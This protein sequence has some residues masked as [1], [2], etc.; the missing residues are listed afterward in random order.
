[1]SEICCLNRQCEKFFTYSFLIAF[2]VLFTGLTFTRHMSWW[3]FH[4]KSLEI[5]IF[6]LA[7]CFERGKFVQYLRH[8]SQHVHVCFGAGRSVGAFGFALVFRL[9]SLR[10]SMIRFRLI[11][12]CRYTNNG[13]NTCTRLTR[14]CGSVDK[15]DA[16]IRLF[17]G[18]EKSL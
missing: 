17:G 3:T 18:E 5:Q 6:C 2:V 11:C 12:S 10:F 7:K 1:M 9:C 15:R 14:L 8:L 13:R 4:K 16:V